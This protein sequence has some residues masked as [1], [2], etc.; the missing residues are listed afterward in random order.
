[1]A[2]K[3]IKALIIALGT[4]I[5]EDFNIDKARYHRVIIMCDADSDG[6]HIKTLLLTLFYRYFKPIIQAGFLYI[7]QPPLYRIQSRKRIEYAY[8]ETD[9]SEI[10]SSMKKEKV[11][12]VT[13]Q[14]YKGLGEMNPD[15]LWETTMSPENRTLL[16]VTIESAREADK[17]F[18]TL[19]GKEVFP[20][21]KFIQTHA[22]KVKN[23]DI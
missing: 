8:T 16:Q 2:S 4:A 15:Q 21:K 18:D 17:V 10:L 20:R 12:S 14:R 7:A 1:L 19:M 9:K 22:K 3:E 11:K 5:A 6:N 13:I 23:L